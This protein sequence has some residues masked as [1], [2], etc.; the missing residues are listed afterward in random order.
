M[1]KQGYRAVA[2]S[3]KR[4]EELRKQGCRASVQSKKKREEELMEQGCRE[5]S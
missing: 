3:K 2:Y 1:R 5:F 4:E